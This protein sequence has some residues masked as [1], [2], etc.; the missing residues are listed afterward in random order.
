MRP[1]RRALD[2]RGHSIS[3]FVMMIMGALVLSTGLVIDGGQKVAAA[4]RAGAVAA[5]ASRAAGN[6]AATQR[7]AGAEPAGA[8]VLAAKAYLAGEPGV[9]GSVALQA[10]VVVVRTTVRQPTILLTLIGIDSVTGSGSARAS[11]VA[12]G[13]SR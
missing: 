12:T 5:A 1:D 4:S 8:A 3:L 2:E 13:A 7:M 6:A 11:I 9:V 10:G